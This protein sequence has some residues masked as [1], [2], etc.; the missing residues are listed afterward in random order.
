MAKMSLMGIQH[1]NQTFDDWRDETINECLNSLL[2]LM[3]VSEYDFIREEAL[4]TYKDML[5]KYQNRL[6]NQAI[7]DILRG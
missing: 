3:V 2:K 7:E 5:E 6:A 1:I 4:S